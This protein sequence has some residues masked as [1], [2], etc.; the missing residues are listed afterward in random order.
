[1]IFADTGLTSPTGPFGRSS[2]GRHC[3][4]LQTAL[5][6]TSS[7]GDSGHDH[8]NAAEGRTFD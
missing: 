8:E 6:P 3:S 4:I 7:H 1:M 5:L 2:G